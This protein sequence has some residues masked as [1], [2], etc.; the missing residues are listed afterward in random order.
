[1]S[2]DELFEADQTGLL[3]GF[4]RGDICGRAAVGHSSARQRRETR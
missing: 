1:M 2:N 4:C 3:V